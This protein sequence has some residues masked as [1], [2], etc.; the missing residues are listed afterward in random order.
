MTT[1]DNPTKRRFLEQLH[2][3][4]DDGTLYYAFSGEPVHWK[5]TNT[6]YKRELLNKAFATWPERLQRIQQAR[7]SK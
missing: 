2:K 4:L 1:K 6:D 3:W 7:F 5:D